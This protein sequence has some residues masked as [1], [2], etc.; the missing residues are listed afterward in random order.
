MATPDVRNVLRVPGYLVK[1]PTNL[2]TAF[3]HGG[4]ALGMI[5][6]I[7]VR[8]TPRAKVIAAEEWGGTAVSQVYT[9]ETVILAAILRSWDSTAVASIFPAASGA[10]VNY[11]VATGGTRPGTLQTPHKLVFSPVALDYHPFVYFPAAVGLPDAAAR[12]QLSLAEEIGL[13]VVWR[14]LP[15]DSS[16]SVYQIGLRG[17][18]VL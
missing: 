3:P 13:A 14:A 4:T 15:A 1:D 18:I 8:W 17:S 12:L 9:G 16:G 7:E 10:T 2:A 11:R 6:S 5:R